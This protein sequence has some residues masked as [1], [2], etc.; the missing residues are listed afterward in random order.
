MVVVVGRRD[1]RYHMAMLPPQ[2][3][4]LT[5]QLHF[6]MPLHWFK[7]LAT[8]KA[9][10]RDQQM[11]DWDRKVVTSFNELTREEILETDSMCETQPAGRGGGRWVV[12]Y[13]PG[14]EFERH[15]SFHSLPHPAIQL[16]YTTI[17][18]PQHSPPPLRTAHPTRHAS[19]T[20][21]AVSIQP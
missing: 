21:T 14:G 20:A 4:Q 15:V 16:S 5:S 7:S 19:P 10:V 3:G 17:P 9:A 1:L 2:E 8:R 12:G 13:L 18:P 6:Y 11:E